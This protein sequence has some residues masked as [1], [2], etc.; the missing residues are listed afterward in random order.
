MDV[1]LRS[2]PAYEES[3]QIHDQKKHPSHCVEGQLWPFVAVV[4]G[5]ELYFGADRS[6]MKA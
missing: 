5:N 1:R 3:M 6:Q 4:V 2:T